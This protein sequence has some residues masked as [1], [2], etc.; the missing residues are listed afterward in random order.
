MLSGLNILQGS[1][2]AVIEPVDVSL[3]MSRVVKLHM[4]D[5]CSTIEMINMI[6]SVHDGRDSV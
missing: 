5:K 6:V 2:A 3:L 1:T 4:K